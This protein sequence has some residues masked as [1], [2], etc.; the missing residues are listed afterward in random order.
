MSEEEWKEYDKKFCRRC[1]YCLPCTSEIH[2]QFAL[3]V[4]SMVRRMGTGILQQ[5]MFK[6][7]W[8]KAE[9]CTEC[10][11]CM[12]RCPYGLP[13]PAMIKENLDWVKNFKL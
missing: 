1:D 12:E 13:I 10:G 2:I 5:P 7:I 4:R 11:E 6:D 8:E 9:N 3:G